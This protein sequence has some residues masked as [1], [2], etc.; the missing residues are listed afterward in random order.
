MTNDRQERSYYFHQTKLQV[1]SS[2]AMAAY[3]DSRFRMFRTGGPS[4]ATV[5]LDFESAPDPSRHVVGRPQGD[6]RPFYEM[7]RGE[8]CYFEETDQ[9]YLS[10]GD[11]VRALGKPALGRVLFS[12]VESEPRNLFVASHL[13]LTILLVEILRRRGWYGLHA[14]GFSEGGNAVLIPGTSGIGK[15]TLSIALLRAKFDYLSDDMVFLKQRPEGLVARGLVEDVDITDQS[16]GFFPE[17]N[18]LLQSPK[19]NGFSKRPVCAQEIYG[20]KIVAE[21]RPKAIVLPRVSGKATSVITPIAGDE[22]LL[23]IVPNVLLTEPRTCQAHLGVFAELV[24]QAACYRLETGRDFSRIPSLFREL[25]GC[26]RE[27]VCA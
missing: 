12:S 1:L 17:L 20:T 10:F 16:I 7:P 25:L 8:A 9:V 18:F 5:L 23:D 11:G 14:A 2:P 15:S 24:K 19:V 21:S 22:A 26:H 4:T 13:V 6:A 3:L 27:Q